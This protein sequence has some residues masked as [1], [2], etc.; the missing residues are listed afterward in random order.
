[1]PKTEKR[2]IVWIDCAKFLAIAAVVTDH[3]KGILYEGEALQYAAFFSVSAFLF[4]SGM[5][6]YFSLERRKE[7]ETLPRWT[8]RRL[9]RILAPYLAAVAVYQYVKSGFQFS[10]AHFFIWAVHFNVEGSFYFVLIYLQLILAAPIVYRLTLFCRR[11]RW[12]FL[13]RGVY[14]AAAWCF[15]LA[16]MKHTF[17]LETYGGGNYLFGG[18]YLFLFVMGMIA[19]DMRIRLYSLKSAVPASI[20]SIVVYGGVL[21]FLLKDRLAFDESLFGWALRVN[22]PGITMIGYTL[23]FLFLIF[24]LC[25][26][27]ALLNHPAVNGALR[28]LSWLGRY[29]LYIYL[30]HTIILDYLLPRLTFLSE[31]SFLKTAVYLAGMIGLPVAGKVLYNLAREAVRKKA[32]AERNATLSE[33]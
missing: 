1:M 12:S 32:F 5:T 33:G 27:G 29:T 30:Y 28:V 14:L 25:S 11:G 6:C 10:L 18:T 22:P 13:W 8:G 17:A 20:A 21:A 15:S 31:P 4:L 19:A 2:N 7:E 16:C 23:A 9:W 24:S 26:L 3:S